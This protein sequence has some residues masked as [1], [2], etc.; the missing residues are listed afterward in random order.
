MNLLQFLNTGIKAPE[1]DNREE[2]AQRVKSA[3]FQFSYRFTTGQILMGRVEGDVIVSLPNL[4][5]N[6]HSLNAVLQDQSLQT[7]LHF[8]TVFGQFKLDQPEI[9]LSGSDSDSGSFFCVN[10]RA[11]EAIV[12]DGKQKSWV[13]SGWAPEAWQVEAFPCQGNSMLRPNKLYIRA[14]KQMRSP[15][16]Q[17]PR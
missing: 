13:A 12:F 5:F 7:V 1:S 2:K 17:L 4:V 16:I 15:A 3:C 14:S 8:D 9:L 6:L 10:Y 11:S